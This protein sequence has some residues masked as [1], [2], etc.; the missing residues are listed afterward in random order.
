MVPAPTGCRILSL[1][2][3][4]ACTDSSEIQPVLSVFHQIQASPP[5]FFFGRGSTVNHFKG[6]GYLAP[7]WCDVSKSDNR[8]SR[9]W[10]KQ[11]HQC[12]PTRALSLPNDSVAPLQPAASAKQDQQMNGH[13][14]HNTHFFAKWRP[15]RLQGHFNWPFSTPIRLRPLNAA[16]RKE[17]WHLLPKAA[18]QRVKE[19]QWGGAEGLKDKGSLFGDGDEWVYH[20]TLRWRTLHPQWGAPQMTWLTAPLAHS[21]C[22]QPLTEYFTWQPCYNHSSPHH[23]KIG[24]LSAVET[25]TG[26][27][28]SE[29]PLHGS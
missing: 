3:L 9:D 15:C 24:Q 18:T 25:T 28:A 13:Y 17:E 27:A 23:T 2:L 5:F 21:T 20:N 10:A 8:H 4:L 22:T 26:S 12:P 6:A 7:Q 16:G 14:F 11:G 29:K 19:R 1:I